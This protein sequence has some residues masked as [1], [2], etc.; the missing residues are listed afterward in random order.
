MT[1]EFDTMLNQMNFCGV[2]NGYL[3]VRG[4]F[5]V[6]RKRSRLLNY[7]DTLDLRF[8]DGLQIKVV[9]NKGKDLYEIQAVM[10]F[11]KVE[12]VQ[13][14]G[15]HKVLHENKDVFCEDFKRV[16][17]EIFRKREVYIK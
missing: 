8:N 2:N 12:D 7:G 14:Y 17:E 11:K 15:F 3:E 16:F 13:K 9:L 10:S 1:D 6:I 4:L 5:C